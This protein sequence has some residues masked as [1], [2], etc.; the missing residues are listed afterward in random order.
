MQAGGLRAPPV[1]CDIS[2]GSN[3]GP[4]A[5]HTLL[6]WQRRFPMLHP[7]CLCVKALL[8]AHSLHDASTG[9]LSSF[10]QANMMMAHLLQEEKVREQGRHQKVG[11]SLIGPPWGLTSW[12]DAACR[13]RMHCNW[14]CVH[15]AI[16]GFGLSS[17]SQPNDGSPA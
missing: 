14:A 2:I 9:G 3:S 8:S 6:G 12:E 15:S 17:F 7:L 5:V 10:S 1:C 16:V 13:M 4:A 11:A